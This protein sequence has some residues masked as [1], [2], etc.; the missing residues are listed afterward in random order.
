[1]SSQALNGRSVFDSADHRAR[2]DAKLRRDFGESLLS[3]LDD[4]RT[5]DIVLNPDGRLWVKRQAS[6]FSC[7]GEMYAA[8]AQAAIGTIAAQRGTVVNYDRPILETE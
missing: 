8:Q 2:L 7:A 6:G 3:A 4:P 1:M 5:E